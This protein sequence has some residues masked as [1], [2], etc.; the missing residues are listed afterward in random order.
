[1][2]GMSLIVKSITRLITAF[3]TIFGI[4]LILYGQVSPG[5]GFSGGV[6]LACSFIL[7]TL[8][9]GKDF[10]LRIFSRRGA[11]I[12]DCVGAGLFLLFAWWGVRQG[13]FF[14]NFADLG[15]P[16]RLL[17]G[18]TILYNNIAIGIKV[19][20]CLFGVFVA[21]AVFRRAETKPTEEEEEI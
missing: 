14:K 2:N 10:S 9:F 20:A 1:M 16:F 17:S 21:L 18:G 8:A 15:E 7:L 4:Y 19:A 3:V 5:G 11:S 13:F 6:I 12:W